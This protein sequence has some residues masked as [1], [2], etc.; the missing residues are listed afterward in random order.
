MIRG[1]VEK[2]HIN[3]YL[4]TTV[5]TEMILVDGRRIFFSGIAAVPTTHEIRAKGET[6]SLV[7]ILQAMHPMISEEG[8]L[9]RL[10]DG[11]DGFYAVS[12]EDV[13]AQV[14]YHRRVSLTAGMSS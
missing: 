8:L 7:E 3:F 13:T 1:K 2:V 4:D 12:V 11:Q 10:E 9:E 6:K 5:D 14:I